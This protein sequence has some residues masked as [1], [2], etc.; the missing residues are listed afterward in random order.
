M[1]SNEK[2]AEMLQDRNLEVIAKKI[3]ISRQTLSAFRNGTAKNPTY[4]TIK[5]ISDYL[6]GKSDAKPE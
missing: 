2:I 5:K 4:N 1:L 6:E 3:K